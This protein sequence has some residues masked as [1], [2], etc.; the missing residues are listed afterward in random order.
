MALSPFEAFGHLQIPSSKYIFEELFVAIGG[1]PASMLEVGEDVTV[2]S[3]VEEVMIISSVVSVVVEVMTIS[4]VV[5]VVLEFS[6]EDSVL[7]SVTE[8]VV[9]LTIIGSSCPSVQLKKRKII[10][11]K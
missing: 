11:T 6:A 10:K 5:S 3:E 7:L 2:V 4:S 1:D 9:L 8:E